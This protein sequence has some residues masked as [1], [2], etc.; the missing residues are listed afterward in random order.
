MKKN[1]FLKFINILT[2][3]AFS[4]LNF[5]GLQVDAIE[6]IAV[7]KVFEKEELA[8]ALLSYFLSGKEADIE[9]IL[10]AVSR[11]ETM[12]QLEKWKTEKRSAKENIDDIKREWISRYLMVW[13]KDAV[14]KN[15]NLQ[16][17][18]QEFLIAFE[19]GMINFERKQGKAI[20]PIL[21]KEIIS[22]SGKILDEIF[23]SQKEIN[24]KER[25]KRFD[26]WAS[27][28]A[29]HLTLNTLGNG[30]FKTEED[31]KPLT[32]EKRTAINDILKRVSIWMKY[33]SEN[34]DELPMIFP[35]P[36]EKYNNEVYK[37]LYRIYGKD[38]N[39]YKFEENVGVLTDKEYAMYQT[40]F[41]SPQDYKGKLLQKLTRDV[42]SRII[43][44]EFEKNN[45]TDLDA[46]INGETS[47]GIV[48]KGLTKE[49][50][51]KKILEK[52][53][54]I[55]FGDEF[56][57][58]NDRT[59]SEYGNDASRNDL[60]C[61]SLDEWIT[62]DKQIDDGV[63]YIGEK[64]AGT[65]RVIKRFVEIM[66]D[67]VNEKDRGKNA[68]IARAFV[69]ALRENVNFDTMKNA[70]ISIEKMNGKINSFLSAAIE[71]RPKEPINFCF[72]IDG[73]LTN[74][75]GY[76]FDA[77]MKELLRNLLDL[78]NGKIAII[79]GKNKTELKDCYIPD[80]L[81]LMAS[82]PS[83]G[84]NKNAGKS[85]SVDGFYNNTV[86]WRDNINEYKK[87]GVVTAL[88]IPGE[89]IEIVNESS[90][91]FKQ[92]VLEFLT[93]GKNK[94]FTVKTD[95]KNN[96]FDTDSK[97]KFLGPYAGV[98]EETDDKGNKFTAVYIKENFYNNELKKNPY[99]L[100]QI[101]A[102]EYEKSERGEI[103]SN[104]LLTELALSSQ[105]AKGRGVSDFKL[106]SLKELASV[107]KNQSNLRSLLNILA[108]TRI[109]MEINLYNEVSK[110]Y[111][112]SLFLYKAQ[113]EIDALRNDP[114]LK[115]IAERALNMIKTPSLMFRLN[116]K[117]AKTKE[118]VDADKIIGTL[119]STMQ[120][121]FLKE[122]Y[123]VKILEKD[124]KKSEYK[125]ALIGKCI[126]T[127]TCDKFW[128]YVDVRLEILDDSENLENLM[129]TAI[130]IF[131]KN[132]SKVNHFQA[133]SALET[134]RSNQMFKNVM[135][136]E[137]VFVRVD[138][139]T[140]EC[141]YENK[142][143]GGAY[144]GIFY[145]TFSTV[146]NQHSLIKDIPITWKRVDIVPVHK[147]EVYDS[148]KGG[149]SAHGFLLKSGDMYKKR[150]S[151]AS[152]KY[153]YQG[154]MADIQQVSAGEAIFTQFKFDSTGKKI[155][156]VLNQRL[157][158]GDYFIARPGYF[159]QL[160]DIGMEPLIWTSISVDYS[161]FINKEDTTQAL[162]S[163]IVENI[164]ARGSPI[165]F[166][167]TWIRDKN[168]KEI[169]VIINKKYSKLKY[170]SGKGIQ[171]IKPDV[172]SIDKSGDRSLLRIKSKEESIFSVGS[173]IRLYK[174]NTKILATIGEAV[175]Y[176]SLGNFIPVNIVK[177]K[178]FNSMSFKLNQKIPVDLV[179]NSLEKYNVEVSP[180]RIYPEVDQLSGNVYFSGNSRVVIEGVSV[181][182]NDLKDVCKMRL[183]LNSK[184]AIN[185]MYSFAKKGLGQDVSDSNFK[186]E[187]IDIPANK[188]FLD[189]SINGMRIII[190]LEGS[191]EIRAPSLD[192][193]LVLKK[194]E[195]ILVPALNGTYLVSSNTP[196]SS[197]FVIKENIGV[198]INLDRAL[199]KLG[200]EGKELVTGF[201]MDIEKL[202]GV[203][204]IIKATKLPR[205]EAEMYVKEFLK[206]VAFRMAEI[207]TF[208][209]LKHEMTGTELKNSLRT[210]FN[211]NFGS[212]LIIL[213]GGKGS[214]YSPLGLANKA[215]GI[216]NKNESNA[217]LTRTGFYSS[218]GVKPV[219]GIGRSALNLILNKE[220][221]ERIKGGAK[222]V[223]SKHDEKIFNDKHTPK[224]LKERISV[225]KNLA[226]NLSE[227][228]IYLPLGEK[229]SVDFIDE[230]I[231]E[232]IFGDSELVFI[233]DTHEYGG[234]VFSLLGAVKKYFGGEVP[235]VTLVYEEAAN[236]HLPFNPDMGLVLMMKS[237]IRDNF[238]VMG[239]RQDN[240]L[241]GKGIAFFTVD[242]DIEEITHWHNI[243]DGANGDVKRLLL[244]K[245]LLIKHPHN[246]H[247][248]YRLYEWSNLTSQEKDQ[249]SREIHKNVKSEYKNNI[250]ISGNCA[251]FNINE[252]GLYVREMDEANKK[253]GNTKHPWDILGAINKFYEH[254]SYDHSPTGAVITNQGAAGI[255]NMWK[256]QEFFKMMEQRFM[257]ELGYLARKGV[258][259]IDRLDSI[260][261]NFG[262]NLESFNLFK[263]LEDVF[264]KDAGIPVRLIGKIHLD[265]RATIEKG[266]EIKNSMIIG[267][268]I[269]LRNSSV[270]NSILKNVKVET[271]CEVID[272]ILKSNPNKKI[273]VENKYENEY[274]I[275]EDKRGD[276]VLD[277]YYEDCESEEVPYGM[278]EIMGLS[279]LKAIPKTN[280]EILEELKL[281]RENILGVVH[282]DNIDTAKFKDTM[283]VRK[284]V[285]AHLGLLSSLYETDPSV[286][287]Q[288]ALPPV[289]IK[290]LDI[291]FDEEIKPYDVPAIFGKVVFDL[292]EKQFVRI[293]DQI[294]LTGSIGFHND[295]IKIGNGTYLNNVGF[296]VP[297]YIGDG[298]TLDNTNIG[299]HFTTN[300]GSRIVVLGDNKLVLE[301]GTVMYREPFEGNIYGL[302]A[303]K[304]C[305][306]TNK[307]KRVY[308]GAGSGIEKDDVQG[309]I[310]EGITFNSEVVIIPEGTHIAGNSKYNKGIRQ[311]EENLKAKIQNYI[312]KNQ[313]FDFND[314][315]TDISGR[316][317]R[318]TSLS[319]AISLVI[320][321]AKEPN[322]VHEGIRKML[323]AL[324]KENPQYYKILTA[325]LLIISKVV[326]DDVFN[327]V[328]NMVR[329]K[330]PRQIDSMADFVEKL[331][332]DISRGGRNVH[333]E[334]TNIIN[335]AEELE[336]YGN[337][338]CILMKEKKE[339]IWETSYTNISSFKGKPM[340]HLAIALKTNSILKSFEDI[341]LLFKVVLAIKSNQD[342]KQIKG[343][344]ESLEHKWK[345]D[346]NALDK[347]FSVEKKPED[348][349]KF[350]KEKVL[351]LYKVLFGKNIKFE[352]GKVVVFRGGRGA[353]PF[354]KLV[355]KEWPSSEIIQ[356]PGATDDGRS[357][358]LL[359]QMLPVSGMPDTGKCNMD[360]AKDKDLADILGGSKGRI[361]DIEQ[362]RALSHYAYEKEMWKKG[363]PINILTQAEKDILDSMELFRFI[364]TYIA[365]GEKEKNKMEKLLEY[366]TSFYKEVLIVSGS[367]DVKEDSVFI[368]EIQGEYDKR[369]S[370]EE[371]VNITTQVLVGLKETFFT[372]RAA[373]AIK[374]H[375]EPF[376]KNFERY[377]EENF[378]GDYSD[379]KAVIGNIISILKEQFSENDKER[380]AQIF[381]AAK[382][383]QEIIK[384]LDS[385]KN[386]QNKVLYSLFEANMK[387]KDYGIPPRSLVLVGAYYNHN[388][389]WKTAI[390]NIGKIV[391]VD[392]KVIP[393]TWERYHLM[394]MTADGQVLFSEDA[395][396]EV[397]K[398]SEFV[399]VGLAEKAIDFKTREA[400]AHAENIIDEKERIKTKI[401]LLKE[402]CDKVEIA[403]SLEA[404]N[405]IS[406]SDLLII[407]PTTL[408]SNVGSALISPEIGR[409]I[410][411][412]KALKVWLPNGTIENDPPDT[413]VATMLDDIVRMIADKQR[414]TEKTVDPSE[415]QSILN[416]V[417]ARFPNMY[418][419]YKSNYVDSDIKKNAK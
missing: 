142:K 370:M 386:Q 414:Y 146:G 226:N 65:K 107:D 1:I 31:S 379:K 77:E 294:I 258:V 373:G 56:S 16:E 368:K 19:T 351:D 21:V 11:A 324:Y 236:S 318:F 349:I 326:S 202:M 279:K 394:A 164:L 133:L 197:I 262:N 300:P 362:L 385:A 365:Q 145:D 213:S 209:N 48:E 150:I 254:I 174:N 239:L 407:F 232:R 269:L 93:S 285:L 330:F 327:A 160:T 185:V 203:E 112:L 64:Q 124:K 17:R 9:A 82:N 76:P 186:G 306:F 346:I 401:K 363:N 119:L 238:M 252:V 101:L 402:H 40:H 144:K 141:A 109:P 121:A 181:S 305:K 323:E 360:L 404:F 204:D 184:N 54:V 400:L 115:D 381:K 105:H 281:L 376:I 35:A 62:K 15:I 217:R 357:W 154:N 230:E 356:V 403:P 250:A 377:I 58:G 259:D 30:T 292:A 206:K 367:A 55:F 199:K 405:A 395:I 287:G 111:S 286:K 97:E 51:V 392:G 158:S 383:L 6:K 263:R 165:K 332:I 369:L 235:Y 210:E 123:R 361:T 190:C 57:R 156:S 100:A 23:A 331:N 183:W 67:D 229:V 397:S 344:I 129:R 166:G 110:A 240:F 3:L 310:L 352:K 339:G 225:H 188:P 32:W 147:L 338:P 303:M 328:K 261:I 52:G 249:L 224:Y 169:I 341:L 157:K 138:N 342:D 272:S 91:K 313:N 253:S 104:L 409:A 266:C 267:E 364:K 33:F 171:W 219:V 343:M 84:F 136:S 151:F 283:Y 180:L 117:K 337:G 5:T 251:T 18:K 205:L 273:C 34:E 149:I 90:Y 81:T 345:W 172:F 170:W 120:E 233:D 353:S 214:R 282:W 20:N 380:Q 7:D 87:Q 45:I 309:R 153:K 163:E 315:L 223:S 417:I 176:K 89:V 271:E 264:P 358:L 390:E 130:N 312:E 73:T 108:G 29:E 92:N 122:K 335:Y 192:D 284:V 322:V 194:G 243:V 75:S 304:D 237:V 216:G 191:V 85:I 280:E 42:V 307:V 96:F 118:D 116:I 179:Y 316:A 66:K 333:Q 299:E 86:K 321:E 320:K 103:E 22:Y 276:N 125:I 148:F 8:P 257:E 74:G 12:P 413:S 255:K 195:S 355:K 222:F 196:V 419:A 247:W 46:V 319:A 384:S 418:S 208:H 63:V 411:Q 374:K 298:W 245:N 10:N 135:E 128:N 26:V 314:W 215:Q 412:S 113:S 187:V 398:T 228:C 275:L 391:E 25:L 98:L 193:R 227:E 410:M 302:S 88:T 416:Y 231:R 80:D 178:T 268:T 59:V 50:G 159:N 350:K 182:M 291:I 234:G 378:A 393:A 38:A 296:Y 256:E 297:S 354:L 396:N 53:P 211:N 99:I 83:E 131:F 78:T 106:F 274:I 114:V 37:I 94:I 325:K 140:G 13:N 220:I 161:E 278:W 4:A 359:S 295:N 155:I 61:V 317:G 177:E 198:E 189:D 366:V 382:E 293:I 72:D 406:D 2:I 137:G 246:E 244:L 288:V 221:L 260:T 27:E 347:D 71:L 43:K 173:L 329:I 289:K 389:N 47:I 95:D 152:T 39:K 218:L 69:R 162:S 49:Y 200:Y 79:T 340:I 242:G 41:N 387:I 134:F 301:N 127:F 143:E 207:E 348:I 308:I 265:L 311:E 241:E 334:Y 14:G 371:S 375:W 24:L 168:I 70:G 336:R 68:I 201:R 167:R 28:S 126:F 44:E 372:E 175:F 212:R 388:K 290:N 408:V 139:L 36:N 60:L 132:K 415:R 277:S 102:R 248:L 270:T 399:F